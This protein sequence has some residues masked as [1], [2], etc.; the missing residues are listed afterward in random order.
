MS[1]GGELGVLTR[2][3]SVE[4][5]EFG[6]WGLLRVLTWG[7]PGNPPRGGPGGPIPGSDPGGAPNA[8]VPPVPPTGH[9]R[10][11]AGFHTPGRARRGVA[12]PPTL[13]VPR[14]QAVAVHCTLGRGRTGTL[15]ACYLCQER[16]LAAPDAIREIRRLRPG[17]V[18]TAGQEQAVISFCQLLA[19]ERGET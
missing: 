10:A 12:V 8:A 15:L 14:R 1:L 9:G 7:I 17:S 5:C 18:E 13:R 11:T 16:H 4:G 6:V 2:G 19:G 3:V